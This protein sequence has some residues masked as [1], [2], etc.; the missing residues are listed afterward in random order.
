MAKYPKIQVPIDSH[1]AEMA[2]QAF[3]TLQE[4]GVSR[5]GWNW[6]KVTE[7][8]VQAAYD[9]GFDPSNKLVKLLLTV[10]L[11]RLMTLIFP[12]A[13]PNLFIQKNESE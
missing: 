3:G 1:K 9:C 6:V 5:F 10:L 12:K 7:L 13:A 11:W 2:E 8:A 4:L